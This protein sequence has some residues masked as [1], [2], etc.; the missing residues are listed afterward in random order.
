[1]AYSE[2]L[3]VKIRKALS[4]LLNVEEQEKMGGVSFMVD[5]KMC[6][7]AHTNNEMMLRCKPEMTEELL[8]IK[9]ARRYEMKGKPMMK[10]W[11][12]I[13]P[14]GMSNNKDFNYWVDIALNSYKKP[15]K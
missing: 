4:H 9:G 12:V 8:T 13:S 5:G 3:V 7:R 11:L 6:I 1:M 2:Q 15:G 10:G 14:E